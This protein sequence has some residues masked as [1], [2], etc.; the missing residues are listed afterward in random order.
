MLVFSGVEPC[1][2]PIQIVL[3]RLSVMHWPLMKL[4][5]LGISY[6]IPF[7]MPRIMNLCSTVLGL[8]PTS[9]V[10]L[11]L[12][13]IKI[14]LIQN[15]LMRRKQLRRMSRKCGLL[16]VTL[17]IIIILPHCDQRHDSNDL[18]R[19]RRRCCIK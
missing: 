19:Y 18:Y 5:I 6:I 13:P 4:V 2:S 3:S 14:S 17:V 15:S 7:L 9:S 8:D 12:E 16:A 10:A 11:L 1:L